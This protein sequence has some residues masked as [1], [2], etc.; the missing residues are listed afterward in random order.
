MFEF[1]RNDLFNATTY[2]AAVDPK[3]GDKVRSTLKRNQY[4][5]T[6]GGPIRRD[7]LFF[8]GGYQGTTIRQDPSDVRSYV[9]TAAMLAG[10]FTAFA[11]GACNTRGPITLKDR[12]PDG[13]PTGFVNNH[14]NPALFSPAA[15]NIAAR[16]PKTND[17]CGEIVFGQRNLH[18][19][20]QVVG[21]V[22]YQ[23]SNKHSLF[24]RMLLTYLDDTYAGDPTNVLSGTQAGSSNNEHDKAYAF[25][26][27]ST[28]LVSSNTINS[29]RLSYSKT[30]QD[31]A[32]LTTFDAKEIGSKVYTYMPKVMS[33][34]VNSGFSMTGNP[35]RLR[36]NLYQLADDVSTTRGKHQ[37]AFGGRVAQ[38]RTIGETGDTILPSYTISGD[39]TGA[40]LADFLLGK[41]Q[42]FNQGLGS[43]NYLRM[44]YISLY[45]QD[46]W[47]VTRRLTASAG[48]RW[49][50]V[51][52]LEDYRRPVPNVSNFYI[53]RYRQGIRSKVFV[54][55]PPGFVRP[56][57][58]A[59]QQRS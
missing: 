32:P 41:V 51:F 37:F 54:N 33:I 55:A 6:I 50:P 43:G 11:S 46:T 39:A 15:K 26:F 19:E 4:G 23:Q 1:V 47:Q 38:A 52:P 34:T 16:L 30:R 25:T 13:S 7:K 40:G 28:Y 53:D 8:F 14:I 31:T 58:G 59:V 27:G 20:D 22:D 9:P 10:D 29:F 49:S 48:L 3:T 42:T 36:A 18:D 35:R 21:K 5:G 44:K 24:G 56:G 45:A 2:F 57:I 17:P 12:Y